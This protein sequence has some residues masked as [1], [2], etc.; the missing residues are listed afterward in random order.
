MAGVDCGIGGATPVFGAPVFMFPF[1]ID[2]GCL[3]ISSL[4]GGGG[5]GGDGD[6]V[7]GLVSSIARL[8][9]VSDLTW[10]GGG[11]GVC[12][13]GGEIG[14]GTLDGDGALSYSFPPFWT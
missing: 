12:R 10:T 3:P 8:V 11:K 2:A 5:G 13:C 9:S 14:N 1:F 7:A 6:L 4:G